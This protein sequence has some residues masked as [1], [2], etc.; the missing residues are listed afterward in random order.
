VAVQIKGTGFMSNIVRLF[1]L[2]LNSK[3]ELKEVSS[4]LGN[5]I[6]CIIETLRKSFLM[7]YGLIDNFNVC[8]K[9]L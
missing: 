3:N 4:N 9:V 6:Y 8:L 2:G 5:C 1:M 7:K